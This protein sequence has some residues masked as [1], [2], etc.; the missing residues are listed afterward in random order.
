M[1]SEVKRKVIWSLKVEV[2]H[3]ING[4]LEQL[5]EI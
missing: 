4:N 1:I 3:L 5:D 2:P